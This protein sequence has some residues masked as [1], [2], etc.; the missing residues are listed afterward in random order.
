MSSVEAESQMNEALAGFLQGLL[1]GSIDIGMSLIPLVTVYQQAKQDP[2]W[3]EMALA[4]WL[5]SDPRALMILVPA[6]ERAQSHLPFSVRK[7]IIVAMGGT[8]P[9]EPRSDD[10]GDPEDPDAT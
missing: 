10:D 4:Q 1:S 9:P 8:P 6:L 2:Q 3:R 7:K 5:K